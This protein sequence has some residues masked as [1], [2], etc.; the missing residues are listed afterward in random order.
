MTRRSPC[1]PAPRPPRRRSG[2]GWPR[3]EVRLM[4]VAPRRRRPRTGSATCPS[5]SSPA[6]SSWSTPRRRCR[7][8]STARRADG[9]AVPLHV[10][11]TLDDGDWVVELRR[12]RQPR[13][14]PRRRA[15]H[16]CSALPGGV[17]AHA[18]R[19]L[20]RPG[21]A[22]PAVAGP[23]RPAGRR[24]PATCRAHGAPIRYGYLRG[25]F[26]LAAYQ[27]VYA[28][29]ARAAPRWPAPAGRSPSEVLVALMARG[30]P[31]V[32]LTLHTGVSSPELHEPPY[33]ERFAVPEA[34]ARLVNSTRRAGGGW[35]R[36][37]R[38][39][40]GRW[41]RPPT[42]TAS[43]AAAGWTDLVLGPTGRPGR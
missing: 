28:D 33:P 15:G 4:A 23:H 19:R 2:A 24:R 37:A 1:R 41:R 40:P 22:V 14:R 27:N 34:T 39:S 31:V 21:P 5:C 18:A 6:T 7:R 3:D 11:T 16:A 30:I 38:P 35:S 36:S 20:P 32:P 43:P 12:P 10:S 9:V 8:G 17:A 42:T 13:P 25:D 29:R 26:P